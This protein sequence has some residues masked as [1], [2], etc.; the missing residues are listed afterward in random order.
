MDM[1]IDGQHQTTGTNRAQRGDVPAASGRTGGTG[2][3]KVAPGTDRVE[4]SPD[5]RL[6]AKATSAIL[7]SPDVRPEAVEKGRRAIA[8]GSAGADAGRLADS[9]IKHL[10]G[11]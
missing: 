6:L 11:Q 3:S 10:L 4:T 7:E 9:I 5:L 2:T 1:K 8:D